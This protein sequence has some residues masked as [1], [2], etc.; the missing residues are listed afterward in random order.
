VGAWGFPKVAISLE[1][2]EMEFPPQTMSSFYESVA[3]QEMM[4]RIG[5]MREKG[6]ALKTV[7]KSLKLTVRFSRGVQD[8]AS[9]FLSLLGGILPPGSPTGGV[10]LPPV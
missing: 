3:F 8:P 1:G 9:E 4:G 6:V 10:A 7:G 2:A 5:R